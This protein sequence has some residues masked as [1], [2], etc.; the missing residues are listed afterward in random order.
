MPYLF[1]FIL[2]LELIVHQNVQK[3]DL[4]MQFYLF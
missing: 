4:L 2:T 1:H 3:L